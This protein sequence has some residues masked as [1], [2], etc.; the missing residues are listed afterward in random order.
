MSNWTSSPVSGIAYPECLIRHPPLEAHLRR[1]TAPLITIYRQWASGRTSFVKEVHQHAGD[2]AAL[3]EEELL[4]KSQDLSAVLR[5]QGLR[6]PLVAEAFAVVREVAH[7][8]IGLRPYD[9]QVQGGFV[10]LHGCIAE[11]NTGE[12]KTLTA[13]LPA[14]TM[15]L[16][17]VPVHIVTVNDYLAERDARDMRPVYEALGLTVGCIRHGLSPDERRLAYQCDVTYCTNKELVFDYLKDRLVMGQTRSRT[18]FHV[19]QLAPSQR[20]SAP[21][22]LRGLHYAIVDEADS[23]LIDEAK[24]PLIIA[25]SHSD[26]VERHIYEESLSLARALQP[27]QDFVVSRRERTVRLTPDGRASLSEIGSQ[28]GGVWNGRLRRESFVQQ[29]LSA[30]HLFHRDHHYLI[31]DEKVHIIDE[32][33]GRVLRDRSWERGLHQMVEVKEECP[34]SG[35]QHTLVQISFQRF[36]RRYLKLAGMT[37]TAKEV[38]R[39]IAAVYR[40]PVVRIPTN[41]P[42]HRRCMGIHVYGATTAKWDAVIQSVRAHHA[43]GRPVLIGTRTVA[44]SEHVSTLLNA[45]SLPHCVLNARQN[46]EEAE[47]IARAGEPCRITVATNMAGRGTDIRLADSIP[48]IGGLHV[49]ATECH[50]ARRIDR[51]LYGRCG[52]QG[53]PGTYETFLSLEDQLIVTYAPS[54]MRAVLRVFIGTRLG[55][56]MARRV[57]RVA[58]WRAQR[59][60]ARLRRNVLKVD[61]LIEKTLGYAGRGE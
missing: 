28:R 23:V 50:E 26:D 13:T 10:L 59:A 39:E 25:E 34:L 9:V 54:Y 22:L 24:T 14:A 17:G 6:R 41:R 21:L 4:R 2:L 7:R 27:A 37:G 56:F 20:K 58:Q 29:A 55:N 18:E 19:K 40:L 42:L 36:F 31:Q 61:E 38:A 35:R 43:A 48:D 45:A 47:L 44:A 5:R 49:I 51:Q 8:R 60:H 1:L 46:D 52:R 12:G 3:S 33:T 16:S 53:D 11:M 30:L 32:Y 15:A 57:F